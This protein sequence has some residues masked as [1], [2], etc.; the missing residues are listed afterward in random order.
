MKLD[1]QEFRNTPEHELHDKFA[2]LEEQVTSVDDDDV[3]QF[4]EDLASLE[5][6]QIVYGIYLFG[7]LAP[8]RVLP[9]VLH[10]MTQG[11]YAKA[12]AVYNVIEK[13]SPENV[14]FKIKNGIQNTD[15]PVDPSLA[16]LLTIL[17][18]RF[19]DD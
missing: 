11:D 18:Q 8:D 5:D 9:A 1:Y 14:S 12:C 2:S 4:L 6:H 16:E 7:K 19:K 10:F 13:L 3:S 15:R 17:K